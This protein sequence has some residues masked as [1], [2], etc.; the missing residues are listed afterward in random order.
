M[1]NDDEQVKLEVSKM[2]QRAH[3]MLLTTVIGNSPS[4]ACIRQMV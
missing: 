3:S 2:E 4:A 1:V